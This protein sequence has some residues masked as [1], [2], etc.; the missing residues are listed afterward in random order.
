MQ[1]IDEFGEMSRWNSYLGLLLE[2]LGL[3]HSIIDNH[4]G[5][6]DGISGNGDGSIGIIEPSQRLLILHQRLQDKIMDTKTGRLSVS[7]LFF[8]NAWPPFES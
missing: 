6:C 5:D 4:L 1:S 2:V 8:T 3:A 7:Y